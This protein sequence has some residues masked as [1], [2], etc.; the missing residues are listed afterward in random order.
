[1]RSDGAGGLVLGGWFVG[2]IDMDGALSSNGGEDLL[3]A[4]LDDDGEVVSA[5]SFGTPGDDRLYR[6]AAAPTRT[7]FVTQ[8]G[9]GPLDFG[10]GPTTMKEGYRV[11]LAFDAADQLVYSKIH[12]SFPAAPASLVINAVELAADGSVF[13][14]GSKEPSAFLNFGGGSLDGTLFVARLDPDGGHV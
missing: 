4:R 3:M 12:S 9:A 8:V 1:V 13:F 7:V 5:R 10:D 2:F 14:A 11:V 6:F